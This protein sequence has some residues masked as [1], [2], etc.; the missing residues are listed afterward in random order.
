MPGTSSSGRTA[1]HGNIITGT[2]LIQKS[3]YLINE[4]STGNLYTLI[5]IAKDMKQEL[6]RLRGKLIRVEVKI[7]SNPSP[8]NY[9]A[10]LIRILY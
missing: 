6:T 5:S 3:T 7:V 9:N 4:R 2:V 10:Q 8:G 1:E